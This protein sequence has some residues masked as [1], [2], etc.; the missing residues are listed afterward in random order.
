M[1]GRQAGPLYQPKENP[2]LFPC[3]SY[4]QMLFFVGTYLAMQKMSP[5]SV[6]PIAL[7]IRSARIPV[8]WSVRVSTQGERVFWPQVIECGHSRS[9]RDGGL[10][11]DLEH[12]YKV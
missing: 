11:E 3:L 9:D 4:L 5:I 7:R 1:R 10:L 8:R 12:W 6:V 2:G